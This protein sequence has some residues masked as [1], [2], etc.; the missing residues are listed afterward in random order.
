MNATFRP[1]STMA[2]PNEHG[3]TPEIRPPGG[4]APRDPKPPQTGVEAPA[5]EPKP[6]AP[7]PLALRLVG[8]ESAYPYALGLRRRRV[9]QGL[10]LE[11]EAG[12]SLGLVGPNGSGKS[13][14]LRL[15]AGLDRP[16]EGSLEVLGDV[17]S[18]RGT[19]HRI[20]YLPEDTPYPREMRAREVLEMLAGLRGVPRSEIRD[21]CALRLKQVELEHAAKKS[22]SS[23]SRGMLRRFGFAQAT[24]HG[25]EILLLDEP[26]AGLDAMG[27]GVLEDLLLEAKE[28]GAATVIASHLLFDIHRHAR[29]VAVLIEGR[30]AAL[31]PPRELLAVE[32]RTRLEFD[33]LGDEELSA[34]EAELAHRGATSIERGPA[35]GSL[36]A[37]YRRLAEAPGA[38]PGP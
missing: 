22:L 6:G 15:L 9:L 20:G 19:R 30:L 35:P 21:R 5:E 13:T 37:L 34:L 14:L 4:P 27:F 10:D 32:G 28:R 11:L 16:L 29:R 38:P 33:G 36:L 12:D 3:D 2:S 23:F 8:L 18:A 26:T 1:G 17:P 25:P 24:V 7:R 31:G